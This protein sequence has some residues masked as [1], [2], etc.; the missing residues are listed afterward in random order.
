[1][2]SQIYY[3]QETE[4]TLPLEI[5][6]I[7]VLDR[8]INVVWQE[9]LAVC[10]KNIISYMPTMGR[11]FVSHGHR[12]DGCTQANIVQRQ[13]RSLYKCQFRV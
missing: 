4:V 3:K 5:L 10:V 6:R 8:L 7:P 1:M 2:V 12:A 11:S 9:M 13:G